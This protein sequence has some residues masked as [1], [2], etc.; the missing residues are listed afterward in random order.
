MRIT[1][2]IRSINWFKLLPLILLG[3]AL[4]GLMLMH[5]LSW[6]MPFAAGSSF[7]N[8]FT[9]EK[10]AVA[11]YRQDLENAKSV[12]KPSATTIANARSAFRSEA[13]APEALSLLALA[14]NTPEQKTKILD[15]IGKLDRRNQMVLFSQLSDRAAQND[16]AGTVKYFDMLVTVRPGRKQQLLPVLLQAL[17]KEESLSAFRFMFESNP[18]WM[19]EFLVLAADKPETL[20]NAANLRLS[21]RSKKLEL[22]DVDRSIISNFAKRGRV[23]SAIGFYNQIAGKERGSTV[24]SAGQLSW[25]SEYP[26]IDWQLVEEASMRAEILSEDEGLQLFVRDGYGGVLARRIVQPK[27]SFRLV[28]DHNFRAFQADGVAIRLK[29]EN[30]AKNR[31]LDQ[32][33]TE[34]RT[35]S[36][37]VTIPPSCDYLELEVNARSSL[38]AGVVRGQICGIALIYEGQ[39]IPAAKQQCS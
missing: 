25:K 38:G 16:F 28:V 14:A 2:Y 22:D 18:D 13:L 27:Q 3:L 29:C 24:A 12:A 23:S 21:I 8:G 20:E 26:P 31:V 30:D 36:N 35:I 39:A 10:V 33:L 17:V 15:S 4:A 6:R 1:S 37:P 32:R 7:A 9:L 34:A 5:S 11:Q 19:S